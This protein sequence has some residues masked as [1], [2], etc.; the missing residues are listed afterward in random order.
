LRQ[1]QLAVDLGINAS[2][3]S[4][5]ERGPKEPLYPTHASLRSCLETPKPS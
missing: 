5:L 1:N 3:I 2:Y 4:A